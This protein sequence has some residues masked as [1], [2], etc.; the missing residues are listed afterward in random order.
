MVKTRV[1]RGY[2]RHVK[3]CCEFVSTRGL[4]WKKTKEPDLAISQ[5]MWPWCFGRLIIEI[6]LNI[7]I[8]FG[9]KNLSVAILLLFQC[10][11]VEL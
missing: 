8:I 11:D 6:R 5:D 10:T 7:D 9:Y 4:T 3:E 1:F 2:N